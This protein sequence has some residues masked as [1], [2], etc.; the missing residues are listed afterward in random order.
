[1]KNL[2]QSNTDIL[3][4]ECS[5]NHR[6]DIYSSVASLCTYINTVAVANCEDVNDSDSR[7]AVS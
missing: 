5:C 3:E 6:A 4:K 1:M 7:E 2:L